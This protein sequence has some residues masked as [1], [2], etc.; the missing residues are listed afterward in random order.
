MEQDYYS[1][2]HHALL[3]RVTEDKDGRSFT[4]INASAFSGYDE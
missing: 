3:L 1:I 2:Q 4:A